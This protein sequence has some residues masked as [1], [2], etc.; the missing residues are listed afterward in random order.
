MKPPLII[1]HK[2]C[3]DG[4]AAAAVVKRRYP[5]AEVVFK[6]YGEPPPDVIGRDLYI[7]DFSFP[8]EVMRELKE[9]A[10]EV[11]WIDHHKT[12]L[13]V[14]EQLGWGK[15]AMEECGATLT[16]YELGVGSMPPILP[17][18][19]DRDL[20]QWQ[21]PDSKEIS[22]AL[23]EKY[24]GQDAPPFD[25]QQDPKALI[26]RGRQLLAEMRSRVAANCTKIRTISLDGYKV[27]AINCMS[28]ISETGDL[29]VQKLGYSIAMMYWHNGFHW[30]YSL[31]GKDVDVSAIAKKRGG[32]GH[33]LAAGFHSTAL[34]PELIGAT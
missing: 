8:V 7:V 22:E 25:L 13:E 29:A 3:L 21:L 9:K 20:W 18:I 19:K 33:T 30:I 1:S 23:K 27:A 28:D 17:Y 5:D 34:L 14:R 15:L 10:K 2:N 31:R 11:T 12:A 24:L 16:W 32:G 4:S 6:N 26:A